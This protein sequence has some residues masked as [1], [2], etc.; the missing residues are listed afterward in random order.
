MK[1][2]T[3]EEVES[4]LVAGEALNLIDVREPEEVAEGHIPNIKH[5]PLGDLEA[6]LSELN[7]ETPYIIVC[8]SGN[9]SGKATTFLEE[10]GFDVTNMTGGMLDWSG[11]VTK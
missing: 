11:E 10:N 6:R 2:I 9:R 3:A 5:I 8:R 7:K 4:K 1:T